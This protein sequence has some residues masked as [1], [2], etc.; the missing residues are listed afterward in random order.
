[1]TDKEIIK[2]LEYVRHYLPLGKL[3]AVI[4][5][6]YELCNRQQKEIDRLKTEKDNLIKTYSECQIDNIKEFAEK[7]E[8]KLGIPFMVNNQVVGI[9]LDETIE[10]MVGADNE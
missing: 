5:G 9:V 8:N 6:A 2:A 4:E 1:M 10:E 3:R 7:V